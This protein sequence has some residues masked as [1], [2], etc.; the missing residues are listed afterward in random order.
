MSLVL[1][2]RLAVSA[3]DESTI[4]SH[5]TAKVTAFVNGDW[6]WWWHR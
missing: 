3:A 1:K 4:L 6:H 5:A 2:R